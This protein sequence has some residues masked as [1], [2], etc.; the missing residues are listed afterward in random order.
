MSIWVKENT[1]YSVYENGKYKREIKSQR[2][3]NKQI[4]TTIKYF[5]VASNAV[6][7]TSRVSFSI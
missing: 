5:L 1:R 3:L 7:S 4:G 6:I 2:I